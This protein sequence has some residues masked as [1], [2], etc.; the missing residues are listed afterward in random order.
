[1]HSVLTVVLV[2]PLDPTWPFILVMVVAA[3]TVPSILAAATEES[4]VS[5]ALPPQVNVPSARPYNIALLVPSYASSPK[6]PF[7]LADPPALPYR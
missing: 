2:D 5:T 6:Y 1:M 4:E 3:D 7:T